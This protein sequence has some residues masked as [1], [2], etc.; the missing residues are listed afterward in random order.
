MTE[1]L[2]NIDLISINNGYTD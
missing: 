2:F 1:Q